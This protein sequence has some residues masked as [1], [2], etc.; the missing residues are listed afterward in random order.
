MPT[1]LEEKIINYLNKM[2]IKQLK[3]TLQRK[4]FFLSSSFLP[5]FSFFWKK[6]KKNSTGQ[7]FGSLWFLCSQ[8]AILNLYPK[9]WNS[10]IDPH[11][12]IFLLTKLLMRQDTEACLLTLILAIPL[13]ISWDIL[14]IVIIK[15]A[16][17]TTKNYLLILYHIITK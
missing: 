15:L 7:C 10:H 5:S 1:P 9:A 8:S 11:G 12:Q 17:E 16:L 13:K 3:T 4:L 14:K 6:K 2:Q